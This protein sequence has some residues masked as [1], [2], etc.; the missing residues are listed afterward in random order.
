VYVLT[1]TE[2]ARDAGASG[3][4]N[5]GVEYFVEAPVAAAASA[6]FVHPQCSSK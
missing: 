1:G 5:A 3:V 2:D 4:V 6:V